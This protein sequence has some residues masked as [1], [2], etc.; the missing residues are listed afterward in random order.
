MTMEIVFGLT[1]AALDYGEER[2]DEQLKIFRPGG[3]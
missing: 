2:N 3:A 1:N